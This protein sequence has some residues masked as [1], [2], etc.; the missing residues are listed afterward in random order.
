MQLSPYNAAYN[1]VYNV[2]AFALS[3]ACLSLSHAS[4]GVFV[5]LLV[6]VS[7]SPVNVVDCILSASCWPCL[8]LLFRQLLVYLGLVMYLMVSSTGL[9]VHI[10]IMMP[11]YLSTSSLV[12]LVL[13]ML[14]LFVSTYHLANLAHVVPTTLLPSFHSL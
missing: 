7:L 14:L 3:A 1:A 13:V 12:N 4:H 10:K 9:L 11:L 2:V 5:S 6:I 8:S